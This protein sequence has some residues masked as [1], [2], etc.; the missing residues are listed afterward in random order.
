[1]SDIAPFSAYWFVKNNSKP[2][3]YKNEH[4]KQVK[5]K[6]L[7]YFICSQN[8]DEQTKIAGNKI[9]LEIKDL[10]CL[11][12]LNNLTNF[13]KSRDTVYLKFG[14]EIQ[15]SAFLKLAKIWTSKILIFQKNVLLYHNPSTAKS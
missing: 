7:D 8:L 14:R 13:C 2:S 9:H 4:I 12:Y 15:S 5:T 10:P 11:P 3:G 1:M 6:N